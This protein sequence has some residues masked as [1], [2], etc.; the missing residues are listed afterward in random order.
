VG[1]TLTSKQVKDYLAVA[2]QGAAHVSDD[3]E[4][5]GE[6]ANNAIVQLGKSWDHISNDDKARRRWVRVVAANHA[7][8]VGAKL[9]REVPVGEAGS[10][11]PPLYDERENGRIAD[12]IAAKRG[13]KRHI[14]SLVAAQVDFEKR[15]ALLNGEDR[16]LLHMKYV[17]D[18][19]S[20]DIAKHRGRHESP[21]TIDNKLTKAK[22]AAR[23][24][25]D[26][27]LE[28]LSGVES[29]RVEE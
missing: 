15:W 14:S 11:P 17:L 10:K 5:I 21:G 3:D 12:L 6:A 27:Q 2:R 19:S 20:K 16:A 18:M 29:E 8:R 28:E 25:F 13:P 7:K 1:V 26:D 9:H 4:V 23:F 22:K 24:V